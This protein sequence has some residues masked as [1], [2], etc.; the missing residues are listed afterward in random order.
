MLELCLHQKNEYK[1]EIDENH[2]NNKFLR[3]EF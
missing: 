3:K 2:A 1:S